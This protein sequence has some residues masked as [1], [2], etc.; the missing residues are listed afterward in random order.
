M[1]AQS[2]CTVF[3][4]YFIDIGDEQSIEN[5]LSTYSSHLLSM[6]YFTEF[7]NKKTIVFIDEFGTGT[8]PQFGAAIAE[9]ILLNLNQSGVYGV[10]TTHYGNLK[11]VASKN[12]GLVNG[13]M[14]YDVD[15]LEPMYQLEIGKPGSSFALEIAL[16]NWFEQRHS[17][18]REG[19]HW[20]RAGEIRSATSK[21]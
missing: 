8:E 18:I 19:E 16:K 13:A 14:R 15:K 20:R 3:D 6:K 12:Q 10:I 9:A 4:N 1:E 2:S 11:E 7:A 17:S 5:D 21:T